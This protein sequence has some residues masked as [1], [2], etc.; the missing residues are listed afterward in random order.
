MRK[1]HCEASD[2]LH[3]PVISDPVFVSF[4]DASWANR[5]DLGSQCGYLCI[6][7]ERSKKMEVPLHVVQSPGILADVQEL[8]V[9]LVQL[10]HS[11]SRKHKKRLSSFDFCGWKLCKEVM[12][13]L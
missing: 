2:K 11:P 12:T 7:T 10:K 1:A 6:G 8:H 5:K 3:Y 13:T 9:H 4:A